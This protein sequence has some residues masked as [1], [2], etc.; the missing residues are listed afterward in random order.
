MVKDG[1]APAERRIAAAVAL[2]ADGDDEARAALRVAADTCVD[3]RLRV[4]LGGAGEMP[5]E[6]VAEAIGRVVTT[7]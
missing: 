1:A 3:E 2:S 6:A 5:D 7:R 4:V